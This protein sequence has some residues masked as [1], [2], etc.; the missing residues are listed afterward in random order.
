MVQVAQDEMIALFV[1]QSQGQRFFLNKH[2]NQFLP[3]DDKDME[4][5]RYYTANNAISKV[6]SILDNRREV[7]NLYLGVFVLQ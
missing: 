5:P 3:E 2:R 4:R 6:Y 7:Q 1:R